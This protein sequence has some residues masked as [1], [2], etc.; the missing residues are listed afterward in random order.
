MKSAQALSDHMWKSEPSDW[1]T[2][3]CTSPSFTAN[4]FYAN[5][6]SIVTN[7]TA[8]YFMS[9]AFLPLLAKGREE[10]PGISTSIG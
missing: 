2:T 1:Q 8:H 3:F 6:L 7:V 5:T 10:S 4:I 9:A